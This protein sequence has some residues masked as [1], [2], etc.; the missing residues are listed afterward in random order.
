MTREEIK[1]L[2]QEPCDDCIS[3]EAVLDALHL[4]GRPTKRFEYFIAIKSDI[5]ALPPVIPKGTREW[6][7]VREKLPE[8][9]VSVLVCY[10]SQGGMAQAVSERFGTYKWSGLG[11][12]EPIAW[13]PL[14][15]PYKE[16]YGE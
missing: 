1:V 16:G 2:E 6:I 11:G 8:E 12:I 13:M 7:S 15:G 4:E 9:F 10:K 3:R 14:P 5:I